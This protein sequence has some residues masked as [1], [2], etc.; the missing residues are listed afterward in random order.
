MSFK[1]NIYIEADTVFV[2][3]LNP[4]S[5]FLDEN[6]NNR[7]AERHNIKNSYNHIKPIAQ[8]KIILKVLQVNFNITFIIPD[9]DDSL[10]T[11]QEIVDWHKKHFSVI[12]Q[13]NFSNTINPNGENFVVVNSGIQ[14]NFFRPHLTY[15][16]FMEDIVNDWPTIIYEIFSKFKFRKGNMI[17]SESGGKLIITKHFFN[18]FPENKMLLAIAKEK[19]KKL[20]DLA[21]DY[22]LIFFPEYEKIVSTF[23]QK[24]V[25]PEL[26][27]KNIDQLVSFHNKKRVKIGLD[28]LVDLT[29]FYFDSGIIDYCY[30]QILK[31]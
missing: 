2:D 1:P 15:S 13:F 20:Y 5:F 30:N 25:M 22:M 6:N 21:R 14:N 11:Y 31:L 7:Y 16:Y 28:P 17:Y 8:A 19:E 4:D 10:I 23:S 18:V 12:Y 27:Q 3:A 26:S 29:D 24:E 9:L